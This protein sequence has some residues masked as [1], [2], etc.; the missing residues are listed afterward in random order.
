MFWNQ[1]SAGH[2]TV[3]QTPVQTLP[4]ILIVKMPPTSSFFSMIISLVT[5]KQNSLEKTLGQMKSGIHISYKSQI[6]D[7]QNK[8]ELG[9]RNPPA[10]ACFLLL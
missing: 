2:Q 7:S 6:V 4:A 9:M 5:M 3:D 8:Q 1:E 10:P